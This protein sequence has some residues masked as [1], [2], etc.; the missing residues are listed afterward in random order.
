VRHDIEI[1]SQR[2][3]IVGVEIAR[4]RNGYAH[5]FA[6]PRQGPSAHATA[7]AEQFFLRYRHGAW[8]SVDS[9]TGLSCTDPDA[10]RFLV[11][12][13]TALGYVTTAHFERITDPQV[14]A[15]R[16]VRAWMRHD[17]VAAGQLVRNGATMEAMFSEHAP[18]SE[19]EAIPCRPVGGG[20]FACS[21][22]LSPHAELTVLVAGGAS[23]G[24]AVTGVEW[25]D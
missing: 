6:V 10:S 12:A 24:Y 1:P 17:T 22:T 23:A 5:I 3:E 16:L 4:C 18:T 11:A 8:S 20:L 2:A 9:G 14:A 7:E 25:G 21:Y 13:C 15:D 19:P